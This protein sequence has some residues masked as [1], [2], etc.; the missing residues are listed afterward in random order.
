MYAIHQLP[1]PTKK[2]GLQKSFPSQD[3]CN[4][5]F[6]TSSAQPTVIEKTELQFDIRAIYEW[7]TLH[8]EEFLIGE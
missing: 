2:R 1:L 4:I 3:N 6:S 7:A 8:F 5:N